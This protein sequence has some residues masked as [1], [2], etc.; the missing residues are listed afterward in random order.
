M[1]NPTAKVQKDTILQ[2]KNGIPTFLGLR[3]SVTQKMFQRKSA[4]SIVAHVRLRSRPRH[5][6]VL[7]R[8]CR[9]TMCI[10]RKACLRL[11]SR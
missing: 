2:H 8:N 9:D 6:L 7:G 5:D 4:I 11:S 10:G 3:S 1:T